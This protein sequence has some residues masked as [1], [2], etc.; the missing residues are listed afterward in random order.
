MRGS[1]LLDGWQATANAGVYRAEL[2]DSWTGRH[3]PYHT[4]ISISGRDHSPSARPHE[5]PEF[6]L[7]IGQ[8]F[9]DG[10]PLMQVEVLADL[11]AFADR[12]MVS[13]GGEVVL[14]NFG[15]A[16]PA[17]GHVE[18]AVRHRLFAPIRRG[19]GYI[20]VR[21]FIF[22]HCANQGPFPQAGAVSIRGGNHWILERNTICF[23][24]MLAV[25]L[26]GEFWELDAIPDTLPEDQ[27]PLMPTDNLVRH[28]IISD[29]GLCGIAGA[30]SER[31]QIVGNILERNNRL[32]W[33]P[34]RNRQIWYEE[35]AIKMHRM[36]NGLIAANLVR[37]NDAYGIWID[38]GF[39]G[40]RITRNVLLNNLRAG[41]FLELGDGPGLVDNNFIAL[42]RLGDGLYSHDASNV[43]VTH[44][45]FWGNANFGIWHAWATDRQV[46][47]TADDGSTGRTP[48]EH[49]GWRIRH[50]AFICS[51]R[52]AISMPL[53]TGR[54]GD[55][56]SDHNLFVGGG[57][58]MDDSEEH[59]LPLF[60]VNHVHKKATADQVAEACRRALDAAGVPEGRRPNP[61]VYRQHLV[62]PLELWQVFPGNDRHVQT[63][64][65][66]KPNVGSRALFFE[67]D[68]PEAPRGVGPEPDE[69]VREADLLGRPVPHAGGTPG[70]VQGLRQGW[71]RVL[72]WPVPE[73]LEHVPS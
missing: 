42:T 65:A 43:T 30:G 24:G 71:N 37:D 63:M 20:H 51:R 22:E 5:G 39:T 73:G 21:G 55:N 48:V 49:R 14:A 52:G 32:G 7:T 45:T 18:L 36:A 54:C 3:N 53:A 23:C 70:C 44:N 40:A 16:A 28:N 10:R 19:L 57:L 67:L 26:G 68:L 35:G 2:P 59:I 25:D 9:R 4:G 61:A 17:A 15:E 1:E 29:N 11:Y 12:W 60:E 31:T 56:T 46:S 33:I 50:N 13:P 47:H 62:L 66:C 41:I 27:V 64:M 38:N 72:L 34:N 69:R 8:L 6:P 58:L